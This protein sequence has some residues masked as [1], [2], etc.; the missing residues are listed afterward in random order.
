MGSFGSFPFH[1]SVNVNQSNL[2]ILSLRWGTRA[3]LRA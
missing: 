2:R 3:I 1:P